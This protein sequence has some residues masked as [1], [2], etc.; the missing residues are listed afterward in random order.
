MSTCLQ[1]EG[2]ETSPGISD[3]AE[4]RVASSSRG[5]KKNVRVGVAIRLSIFL[6]LKCSH[7]VVVA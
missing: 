3:V 1:R 6:K 4:T 5:G 7:S 2:R